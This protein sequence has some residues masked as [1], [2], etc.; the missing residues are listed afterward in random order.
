[1]QQTRI[2]RPGRTHGTPTCGPDHW[3]DCQCGAY[4]GAMADSARPDNKTPNRVIRVSNELWAR[5]GAACD[6]MEI[7]RSSEMRLHMQAVAEAFE[8]KQRRGVRESAEVDE[9]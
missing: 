8:R 9:S 5:Y 6:A 1:M 4:C 3:T 2:I 7:S